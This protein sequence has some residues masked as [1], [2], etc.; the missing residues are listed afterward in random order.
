VAFSPDGKTLAMTGA[1]AV[2]LWNVADRTSI[3]PPP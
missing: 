3:A 2:Y 1:L